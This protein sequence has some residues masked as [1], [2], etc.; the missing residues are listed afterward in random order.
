MASVNPQAVNE[1]K[2]AITTA[3]DEHT[4][5]LEKEEYKEVLEDLIGDLRVRLEAVEQELEDDE[6]ANG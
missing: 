4:A 6:D 2:E 5:N 1:S 3:I